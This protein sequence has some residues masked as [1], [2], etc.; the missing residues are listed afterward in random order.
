MSILKQELAAAHR[1]GVP[2]AARVY[3]EIGARIGLDWMRERIEKLPVD[4]PWQAI[5]RTGLPPA[6][7]DLPAHSRPGGALPVPVRQGADRTRSGTLER[8]LVPGA[9]QLGAARGRGLGF[10]SHFE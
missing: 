7:D 3:F 6:D 10:I 2:D 1:S 9:G 8:V 4:G 5:A